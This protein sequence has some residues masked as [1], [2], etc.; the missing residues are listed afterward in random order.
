MTFWWVGKE[1]IRYTEVLEMIT[2]M[3]ISFKLIGHRVQHP[4]AFLRPQFEATMMVTT[5]CMEEAETIS[6]TAEEVLP[7]TY[8]AGGT[9]MTP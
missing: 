3:E 5:C 9:A 6:F 2:Y 4:M 7:I 8:K 1:T